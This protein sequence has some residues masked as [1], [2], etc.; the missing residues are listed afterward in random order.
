MYEMLIGVTPFYHSNRNM[1]LLK[2]RVAKV[3]FP[4]KKKYGLNWSNECEDL[5]CKFLTAG[6][7]ERIG[8]TGDAEEILKHP[9]FADIDFDKLQKREVVP[10][11][12]PQVADKFGDAGFA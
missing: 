5:I 8:N 2:I 7:A 11:F 12:K 10:P 4:D 1:Q 6:A 9:F 3:V